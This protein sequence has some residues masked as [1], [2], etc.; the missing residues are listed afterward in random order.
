MKDVRQAIQLDCVE[1]FLNQFLSDYYG[2][3]QSE[4]GPR[5]ETDEMKEVPKWETPCRRL[6]K[7]SPIL[8]GFLI[9]IRG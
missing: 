2:P 7:F 9:E 1:K 6:A 4:S 8:S 5:K 3:I